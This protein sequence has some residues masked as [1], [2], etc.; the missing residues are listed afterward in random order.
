MK[1]RRI[2][3]DSSQAQSLHNL[4][5]CQWTEENAVLTEIPATNG[6]GVHACNATTQEAEAGDCCEFEA[7]WAYT[8]SS[9][10]TQEYRLE[11]R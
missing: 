1:E 2:C 4:E 7:S 6:C 9:K 11:L 8:V 3:V 10:L 5:N